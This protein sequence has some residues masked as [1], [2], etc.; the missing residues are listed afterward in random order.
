MSFECLS[1]TLATKRGLLSF[2][3][4]TKKTSQFQNDDDDEKQD[5]NSQVTS[6]TSSGTIRKESFDPDESGSQPDGIPDEDL[7]DLSPNNIFSSEESPDLQ[8]N[9]LPSQAE[10]QSALFKSPQ[11][12]ESFFGSIRTRNSHLSVQNEFDEDFYE[13]I[14]EFLDQEG[15]HLVLPADCNTSMNAS[16]DAVRKL[17]IGRTLSEN[18]I[19]MQKTNF[20]LDLGD[21][22]GLTTNIR[23]STLVTRRT[24]LGHASSN[25]IE[26]AHQTM[27]IKKSLFESGLNEEL[28]E[29]IEVSE[30]QTLSR[31]SSFIFPQTRASRKNTRKMTFNSEWDDSFSDLQRSG[32]RQMSTKTSSNFLFQG[33][34]Q[35]K[36]LSKLSPDMK[37]T[38]ISLQRKNFFSPQVGFKQLGANDS[39]KQSPLALLCKK[40]FNF[41]P[42]ELPITPKKPFEITPFLGGFS[43][44]DPTSLSDLSPQLKIS[45][46]QN[47]D[48]GL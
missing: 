16:R 40:P 7:T 8:F 30:T 11:K 23:G 34:E 37:P 20:E 41:N 45:L 1:A 28:N 9:I 43:L 29:I 44:K 35:V 33:D 27:L 26:E 12:L 22:P 48:K 32:I 6:E 21:S 14:E 3:T 39:S 19:G 4:N 47:N 17:L 10:P 38:A 5:E 2:K 15:L 18:V 31:R 24:S 46:T 13:R 36:S 25:E 42:N